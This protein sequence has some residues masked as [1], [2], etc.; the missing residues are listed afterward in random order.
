MT[1]YTLDNITD[2]NRSDGSMTVNMHQSFLT[3]KVNGIA[4]R[5]LLEVKLSEQEVLVSGPLSGTITIP[6]ETIVA[7][8]QIRNIAEFGIRIS[9]HSPSGLRMIAFRTRK[10]KAWGD[11]FRQL[12]VTVIAPNGWFSDFTWSR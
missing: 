4:Y 9:Y 8:K 5:G 7:V 12:S 2:L 11:A 6:I 10:Y 3:G 1:C